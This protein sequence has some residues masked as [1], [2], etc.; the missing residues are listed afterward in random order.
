MWAAWLAGSAASFAALEYV[1]FRTERFPTLS[2]TTAAWLG[3]NPTYRY[4]RYTKGAAVVAWV[5]FVVHLHTQ[6]PEV[7]VVRMQPQR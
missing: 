4:H 5:A 1:A 6:P 7:T 2:R 3:I